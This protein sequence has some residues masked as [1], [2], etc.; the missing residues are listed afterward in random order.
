[1][2]IE[3][4]LAGFAIAVLLVVIAFLIADRGDE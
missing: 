2:S 1:M 4:K 3:M